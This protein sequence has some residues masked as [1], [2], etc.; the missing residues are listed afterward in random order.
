V[1][2]TLQKNLPEITDLGVERILSNLMS[3]AID[4]APNK[5]KIT[6]KTSANRGFLKIIF[7][8]SGKGIP[9]EYIDK[10]FDPF[11][12]TKNID[13]GCGLGLTIVSEIVKHYKGDIELESVLNKGTTFTIRLPMES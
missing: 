5:G 2:K 6:I 11:F 12:T 8:N 7:W 9:K 3:N 4:A 10:I 13:Q 1:Q